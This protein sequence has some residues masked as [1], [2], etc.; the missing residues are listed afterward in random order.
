[1]GYVTPDFPNNIWDGMSLNTFRTSRA[2]NIPPDF[3]DWDQIVA[4]II[5]V[6]EAVTNLGGGPSG[7][8]VWTVTA[9]EDIIAGDFVLI[10]TDGTLELADATIA[11]S[12]T[13]V[14]LE[15]KLTGELTE[16]LTHGRYINLTWSLTPGG[17]YFLTE[18]GNM[19]TNPPTTGWVIQLG[20]AISPTGFHLEISQPIK[21]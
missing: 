16:I 17:I 6:Q 18:E 21:L 20:R 10:Q 13:G 5:S 3:H 15:S 12:V 2:D 19:S 7:D 1:M 14:A 9:G 4:E 11:P 8:N